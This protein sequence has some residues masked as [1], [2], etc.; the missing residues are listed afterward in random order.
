[1][2]AG[3]TDVL[4]SQSF[5]L[6]SVQIVVNMHMQFLYKTQSRRRAKI[7]HYKQIYSNN[8]WSSLLYFSS[9]LCFIPI[10][11]YFTL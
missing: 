1:M 8:I 10:H 7:V 3:K 2:D 11:L 6:N 5:P 9:V 4:I